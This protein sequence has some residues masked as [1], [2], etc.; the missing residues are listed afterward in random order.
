MTIKYTLSGKWDSAN[1]KLFM[2]GMFCCET[3]YLSIT[4]NSMQ[5]LKEFASL[6]NP[7]ASTDYDKIFNEFREEFLLDR[8]LFIKTFL[9]EIKNNNWDY[10]NKGIF[11]GGL[12]ND[13]RSGYQLILIKILCNYLFDKK[14]QKLEL[15]YNLELFEIANSSNIN[16]FIEN[17]SLPDNDQ[18]ISSELIDEFEK[19]SIKW[20]EYGDQIIDLN[21]KN[22]I[23]ITNVRNQKSLSFFERVFGFK[24]KSDNK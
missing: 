14:E 21:E 4:E 17:I 3:H 5:Y 13:I 15:N 20:L 2:K 8:T 6:G 22:V 11:L 23:S 1:V 18:I 19:W 7:F 12:S 24:F 10:E 9:S 16:F